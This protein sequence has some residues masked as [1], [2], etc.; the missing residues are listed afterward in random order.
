M[1]I[2]RQ[3][4][5]TND[6]GT[7]QARLHC[8]A[9]ALLLLSHGFATGAHAATTTP[10]PDRGLYAIWFEKQPALLELPFVQGGQIVLQWAE[11]EPEPGKYDFSRMDAQLKEYHG[12]GKKATVQ[13]NGN[14][15]PRYLYE[16]VAVLK[17]KVSPQV[18][19]PQG[20]LQYWDPIYVRHYLD[21]LAAYGKHLRASPYRAAVLGVRLNFNAIGT[22][23]VHV[24]PKF[25]DP[26]TWTP[27]P[28][29][30]RHDAPF[31]D[32]TADEYRR[33]VVGTYVKAFA[34]DIRI[35]V[36]NNSLQALPPEIMKKF[37]T[38]DLGL[39]HTSTDSEPR[40]QDVAQRTETFLRY[41]RTGKT[42]GYAESWMTAQG[43]P[44]GNNQREKLGQTPAQFNYWRLLQDLHCGISFI[45]VY[46]KDLARAQQEPEFDAAFRFAARYAGY[47]ASPAQSPGAWVALREGNLL[48]GDYTFLMRRVPDPQAGADAVANV[49]PRDQR[50]GA[51]ARALLPGQQMRFALDPAFARS[52]KNQPCRLRVVYLDSGTKPLTVTWNA[53]EKPSRRVV[54]R[55]NTG[56]WQEAVLAVPAAGDDIV[57]KADE[58]CVLH[59]VEVQRGG[60]GNLVSHKTGE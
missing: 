34:P 41:C 20:T 51:W 36:R 29:G 45:A 7:R 10:D 59:L 13:V 57:L 21:F 17:E 31:T 55:Q 11:V 27:A 3:R 53:G 58:R 16:R 1:K 2:T 42:V 23:H 25:W 33:A 39:F 56:R 19:D 60:D 52:L 26:K 48:K 47:H 14:H 35:F 37:E 4:F 9:L 28:N 43:W 38:G 8:A 30:H 24:P 46:G 5:L 6:G 15:R 32:R 22:E 54:T 12:K 40:S 49:G 44:Q 50:Y 18:L